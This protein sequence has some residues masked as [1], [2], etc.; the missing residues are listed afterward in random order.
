MEDNDVDDVVGID[1]NNL[2]RAKEGGDV[3][4]VFDDIKIDHGSSWVDESSQD[5]SDSEEEEEDDEDKKEAPEW[6]CVSCWHEKYAISSTSPSVAPASE[7][8]S[9][10]EESPM[11]LK[12][13]I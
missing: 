8:D 13:N 10:E 7:T 11:L 6:F 12:I 1:D 5:G 9:N 3:E 4:E 2:E